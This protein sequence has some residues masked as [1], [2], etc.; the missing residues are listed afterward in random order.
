MDMGTDMYLYGEKYFHDVP[1]W[2]E[3]GFK[4]WKIHRLQLGY[5]RNREIGILLDELGEQKNGQLLEEDLERAIDAVANDQLLVI[6]KEKAKEEKENDLK[7]L[8]DAL[9]WLR[10]HELPHYPRSVIFQMVT[11]EN[12]PDNDEA[13]AITRNG[14]VYYGKAK[15]WPGLPGQGKGYLPSSGENL[16]PP[17]KS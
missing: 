13:V 3:D 7:I 12:N 16:K 15:R 1:R 17:M 10:G 2:E 11:M 9:A 6:D 5:W 14:Q 8:R 4:C